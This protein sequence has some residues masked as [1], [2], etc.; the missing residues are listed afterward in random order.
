MP[1]KIEHIVALKKAVA[2]RMAKKAARKYTWVWNRVI[3]EAQGLHPKGN[4]LPPGFKG[5]QNQKFQQAI[6]YRNRIINHAL[7]NPKKYGGY[8]YRGMPGQREINEFHDHTT[9]TKPVL[10][11]FTKSLD[12]AYDFAMSKDQHIA[13]ILRL[14]TGRRI[15]SINFTSGKFQSEFAPGGMKY[16]GNDEKEVLL[17]PGV[18]KKTGVS[19]GTYNDGGYKTAI[20]YINVSFT[21]NTQNTSYLHRVKQK[22]PPAAV[23][24]V[25]KAVAGSK[26]NSKGRIIQTGPKGGTYIVGG[27]GKKVYKKL[28]VLNSASTTSNAPFGKN[29]KGNI[30]FKGSKGGFYVSPKGKKIYK[31]LH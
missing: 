23:G 4:K 7:K 1:P 17:P 12:V 6:L 29:S 14:R 21:P 18:Y 10:A 3:K 9:V 24:K 13:H 31:F 11:S 16:A 30:I 15:P 19:K 26:K 25:V 28:L 27:S 20:Q 5:T 8:L 22:T 2:T